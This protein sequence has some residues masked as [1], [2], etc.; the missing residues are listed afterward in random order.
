M[1]LL[2]EVTSLFCENA[3]SWSN[4]LSSAAAISWRNWKS[5]AS[6]RDQLLDPIK[7]L[8]LKIISISE[9]SGISVELVAKNAIAL[10]SNDQLRFARLAVLM[11]FRDGALEGNADEWQAVL[12]SP[13]PFEHFLSRLIA[14]EFAPTA[15]AF[16]EA[17]LLA[18]G[19]NQKICLRNLFNSLDPFPGNTSDILRK[20][21]HFDNVKK[22]STKAMIGEIRSRVGRDALKAD[23]DVPRLLR[24]PQEWRQ[25]ILADAGLSKLFLTVEAAQSIITAPY[26]LADTPASLLAS[27]LK[28]K[29]SGGLERGSL[30]KELITE[31]LSNKSAAEALERSFDW[32]ILL[33]LHRQINIPEY[34]IQI[35]PFHDFRHITPEGRLAGNLS[36]LVISAT[37]RGSWG[38]IETEASIA[39]QLLIRADPL[40]LHFAIRSSGSYPQ[41]FLVNSLLRKRRETSLHA[42]AVDAFF[43]KRIEEDTDLSTL[44]ALLSLASADQQRSAFNAVLPFEHFYRDL[45]TSNVAFQ[46]F[47]ADSLA[48]GVLAKNCA[49][50]D[51][52]KLYGSLGDIGAQIIEALVSN[53]YKVPGKYS[54]KMILELMVLH[55]P[56]LAG[57]VFEKRGVDLDNFKRLIEHDSFKT[58]PFPTQ[59]RILN[60]NT[61]RAK[62][63]LHVAFRQKYISAAVA[64]WLAGQQKFRRLNALHAPAILNPRDVLLPEM[65]A[66]V[67]VSPKEAAATLDGFDRKRLLKALPKALDLLTEK[68]RVAAALELAVRSEVSALPIFMRLARRIAP[69]FEKEKY[70]RRFDDLYTT[71]ELP[72]RSGGKRII[73]APAVQLKMVQRALLTLLYAEG[74]SDQAMGFVPGRSTR[75]NAAKHVGRDVVVNADVK[76]FFPSTTYKRVYSLSRTICDGNLSPLAARLFAE[77]CC[78]DGHLATGAPT[79]PAV[80]NLIMKGLDASLNSIASKLDVTYTRYADDMTFS[81]QSPA[82]WMLKPLKAHLKKLGYELDPKK[83]NI[84]RKGR[85]QI[86]TGAVVNTKVNLARP[87]R[88]ILRAAVDHRVKGKEPFFQGR[89]MNDAVL[90]G[91]VA[92]LNMLSPESAAPL[93]SRLKGSPGWAY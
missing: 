22:V 83:T 55:A 68:P 88:K 63:A 27:E 9:R 58:F 59:F 14:G 67:T 49:S 57:T 23:I 66:G 78:H 36:A 91:Y 85:R 13:S 15:E 10:A 70:G 92:Y 61:K 30:Q 73:S 5:N 37:P 44:K 50:V 72:K 74:F 39:Q 84:F 80:S 62:P 35:P 64:E 47:Y 65:I 90:N 17:L 4:I 16:N 81:G 19:D 45:L 54:P 2:K 34:G 60:L 87:L 33:K 29:L 42:V 43:S 51:Q 7:S 77:I 11:L 8:S 28:R 79:S 93:I 86:V 71:Y 75:D 89:P 26:A 53:S 38:R 52:I 48:R 1:N 24:F 56:Q 69:P 41:A 32:S 25:F 12:P 31:I 40:V 20:I 46:N 82:V 3:S 76:A 6:Y 21:Q 18:K